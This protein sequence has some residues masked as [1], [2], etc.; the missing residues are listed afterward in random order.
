M[1]EDKCER[2]DGDGYI[3]IMGD[4]ENFECDVVDTKPCPDCSDVDISNP[5]E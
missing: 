2:C 5:H 4:G 1:E 3:E